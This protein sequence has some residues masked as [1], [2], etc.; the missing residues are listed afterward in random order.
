MTNADEDDPQPDCTSTPSERARGIRKNLLLSASIERQGLSTPARIRNLSESGAMLDAAVLPN[1]GDSFVLRRLQMEIAATVV[2][3]RAGRC[4]VKFEGAASVEDWVAGGRLPEHGQERSQARVDAIQ[5]AVRRGDPPVSDDTP[6][7]QTALPAAELETRLAEEI[8]Y[9]RRI[10]DDVGDE[11]SDDAIVLQRHAQA[12]QN[13]DIA[14][15]ILAHVG[16]ILAAADRSA[17]VEAVTM[18]ELRT[19]LLRKS[20]F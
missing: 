5:A 17:A 20:I 12:L 15:Q 6:E 7:T 16:A 1:V 2:W 13:L 18:E 19:R 10:L 4:G 3:R 14:C 9:A 11:L 8:A